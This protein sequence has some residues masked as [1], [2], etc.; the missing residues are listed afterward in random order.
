MFIYYFLLFIS[1]VL[2]F[3]I[4]IKILEE[5]KLNANFYDYTKIYPILL[6]INNSDIL[7]EMYINLSSNN[8][9]NEWI[10]WPEKYLYQSDDINGNGDWKIIPFYGFGIWCKKNCFKF[11]NL[12]QFLKNIPNLKVALISKLNPNTKLIPHYGWGKHSNNVLRCHYGIFLPKDLTK[13]YISV[14]DNNGLTEEIQYHK[15][16]DWIVFDDSKLHYAENK[17]NEQRIVLIVD[18][19]RP[20]YIKKGKSSVEETSELIEIVN[21]MKL[22]NE[23]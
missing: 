4:F 3:I 17:S 8:L 18:I 10:D 6:N 16:N 20:N 9:S 19:E 5:N 15:L 13:S 22:I 14:S 12:T 7:N 21:K 23:E 11:P 2:I 1:I